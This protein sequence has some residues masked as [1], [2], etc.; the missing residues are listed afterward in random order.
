MVSKEGRRNPE[1]K[2]IN[3]G[4]DGLILADGI[5]LPWAKIETIG[6][7]E[8]PGREGTWTVYYL[9]EKG[10]PRNKRLSTLGWFSFF[11]NELQEENERRLK[12]KVIEHARKW[13]HIRF[14]TKTTHFGRERTWN[15]DKEIEF[16]FYLDSPL[17][18]KRLEEYR[19]QAPFI[20]FG[21]LATLGILWLAIWIIYGKS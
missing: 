1:L 9:R 12:L 18:K 13:P 11:R 7:T 8:Y 5:V 3:C 20:L 6:K 19:R 4:E 2:P 10:D 14:V 21:F 15:L 16:D 17:A